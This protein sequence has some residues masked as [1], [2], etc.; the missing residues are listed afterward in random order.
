MRWS[1]HQFSLHPALGRRDFV[2][3]FR[4]GG[5]GTEQLKWSAEGPGQGLRPRVLSASVTS[6]DEAPT[7]AAAAQPRDCSVLPRPGASS[8]PGVVGKCP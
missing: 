5:Q 2:P 8:P 6:T 7:V 1:L 3:S 4:C